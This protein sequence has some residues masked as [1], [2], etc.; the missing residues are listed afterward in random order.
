MCEDLYSSPCAILLACIFYTLI[1]PI[2]LIFE[3]PIKLEHSQYPY[4]PILLK[5]YVIIFGSIIGLIVSSLLDGWVSFYFI[6]SLFIITVLL[7]C[8]ITLY[9]ECNPCKAKEK[10]EILNK[11][12]S[13][14]IRLIFMCTIILLFNTLWVF[15]GGGSRYMC[16]WEANDNLL[17]KLDD[18]DDLNTHDTVIPYYQYQMITLDEIKNL[19]YIPCES[20]YDLECINNKKIIEI[21]NYYDDYIIINPNDDVTWTCMYNPKNWDMIG[22]SELGLLIT[23]RIIFVLIYSTVEIYLFVMSFNNTSATIYALKHLHGNN[24]IIKVLLNLYYSISDNTFV[25]LLSMLL[26]FTLSSLL[27]FPMMIYSFA[28]EELLLFGFFIF[29]N[30]LVYNKI[31]IL[32][33]VGFNTFRGFLMLK[34]I[35]LTCT[36][37]LYNSIDFYRDSTKNGDDIKQE[38]EEKTNELVDL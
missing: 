3:N 4:E 35:I 11:N 24:K 32:F 27:I 10:L 14:N 13:S 20:K 2:T 31:N 30:P 15:I 38:I 9:K 23:A 6:L 1:Y 12:K 18:Y 28:S 22:G 21:N 37:I 36:K 19:G 5:L 16:S 29:V 7:V 25:P 26:F 34:Y 8:I 17:S 33:N